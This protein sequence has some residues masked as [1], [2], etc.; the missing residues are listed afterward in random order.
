M[1]YSVSANS[2]IIVGDSIVK[3]LTGSEISKKN[4][5]KIKANPD[6]T[7]EDIFDYIKPSILKK[8]DV[9]LVHLG[10][11]ELTNGINTMNKIRKVA[12][13]VDEMDNER[14]LSWVFLQLLFGTMLTNLMKL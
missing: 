11:N 12:A 1:K 9:L 14:T 7:T 4:Y 8:P 5:I 10:T 2:V 13:T 6:V 3:Y